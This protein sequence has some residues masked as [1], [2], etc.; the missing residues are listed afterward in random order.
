MTTEIREV[1][2]GELLAEGRLVHVF[3]DPESLQK[4]EIPGEARDRLAPWVVS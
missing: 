4:R 1:R 2:D 3:V